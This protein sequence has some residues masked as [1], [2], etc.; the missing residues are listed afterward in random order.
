M[1]FHL[2]SSIIFYIY[3]A[4][5]L[6]FSVLYHFL[7]VASFNSEMT[8]VNSIYFSVVTITTLGYGDILPITNVGKSLVA[9]ESIIGI[10][11]IGIFLNSIWSNFSEK[12][13]EEQEKILEIKNKENRKEKIVAYSEY[14]ES[15]IKGH[16]VSIV[17]I[18]Q[19]MEKK[20]S[21]LNGEYRDIKIKFSDLSS[22]FGFSILTSHL[23]SPAFT[24]YAERYGIMRDEL[25]YF[26]A[27]IDLRDHP[28]IKD[29]MID[30]LIKTSEYD[31]TSNFS[32]I[33]ELSCHKNS[34]FFEIKKLIEEHES[35]PDIK[36]YSS[37]TLTPVIILYYAL[38]YQIEML[39]K[40]SKGNL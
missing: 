39:N 35:C 29:N 15:L 30:Y 19:S 34:P 4:I 26:I 27:N 23:M 38:S 31:N 16:L 7:P 40:I 6:I 33:V 36:K 22:A 17:D 8:I 2:K 5:I 18:S 3:I 21:Y 11:L 9:S 24:L 10:I 1:K 13:N 28:E 14:I 20:S 37:H 32:K 25:K 12:I